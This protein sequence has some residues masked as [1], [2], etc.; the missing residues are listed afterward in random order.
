MEYDS[1]DSM[2][3]FE[4][5]K[6]GDVQLT[7]AGTGIRHAEFQHGS[8]PVHFLQ[9]SR[10]PGALGREELTRLSPDLGNPVDERPDSAILH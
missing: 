1:R 4:V 5:M 10:N 9:V 2:G 6:R 7:S 3:N 8:E